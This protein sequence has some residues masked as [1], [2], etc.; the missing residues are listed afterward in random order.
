MK[1]N[2]YTYF[3]Q[4]N[5]E[6]SDARARDNL[7]RQFNSARQAEDWI[8]DNDV[9]GDILTCAVVATDRWPAPFGYTNTTWEKYDRWAGITNENV[10]E[11]LDYK[12]TYHKHYNNEN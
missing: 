10:E 8:L 3:V 9:Q 5:K 1:D 11:G 2:G 12:M 6:K 7:F 4:L